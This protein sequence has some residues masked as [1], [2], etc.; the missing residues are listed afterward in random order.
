[1][2]GLLTVA[3]LAVETDSQWAALRE[4]LG[5]PDWA[6]APVLDTT[7]GRLAAHDALDAHLATWTRGRAPG[8]AMATLLAAGVP[9]GHVQRSSDLQSDPQYR[10]RGFYRHLDHAEMG[11]IPYSGHQF[12]VSGYDNGPRFAAPLIGG[13]NFEVLVEELGF[14]PEEVADLMAS[15][16][17]S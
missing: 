17:I 8:E 5:D 14:T 10:H 12:R 13:D 15:D 11:H 4:V 6:R 3:L 1:M 16:V 2:C 9:A 7:A